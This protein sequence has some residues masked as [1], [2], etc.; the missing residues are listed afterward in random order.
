MNIK[1]GVALTSEQRQRLIT[2]AVEGQHGKELANKLWV[3]IDG[4]KRYVGT[5]EG[6]RTLKAFN[7]SNTGPK[8]QRLTTVEEWNQTIKSVEK[9]IETIEAVLNGDPKPIDQRSVEIIIKVSPHLRHSFEFI[10]GIRE[11]YRN[12]DKE[13]KK[14]L[15]TAKYQILR[16][17]TLCGE[18]DKQI[19]HLDALDYLDDAGIAYKCIFEELEDKIKQLTIDHG[20]RAETDILHGFKQQLIKRMQITAELC[21][22]K[23][24]TILALLTLL[25]IMHFCL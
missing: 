19:E 8:E 9:T 2:R 23:H 17:Y 18:L 16:K 1:K 15:L 6:R 24:A 3:C 20:E 7:S 5:S 22:T 4:R 13:T 25:I 12:C 14:A 10:K 21:Y 11:I